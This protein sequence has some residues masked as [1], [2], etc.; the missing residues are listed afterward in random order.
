M[1]SVSVLVLRIV[2]AGVV[3]CG[4]FAVHSTADAPAAG[5]QR[6]GIDPTEASTDGMIAQT[7]GK[8]AGMYLLPATDRCTHGP[9]VVPP[10][11]RTA[12]ADDG[13][14][15]GYP[16]A[17]PAVC[18][19]DGSSG[20]RLE[21]L[22]V[23]ALGAT[24]RYSKVVNQ[25]RSV[26]TDVDR[27]LALSA[28]QTGGSR[29][30]RFAHDLDC[31]VTVTPVMLNASELSTVDSTFDGLYNRG[32]SRPDRKYIAFVDQ[33]TLCGV[34]TYYNDDSKSSANDNNIGPD[35]ARL[36]TSCWTSQITAHETF[37]MMGA[38]QDSA[39]HSSLG[40]HCTDEW[41]AMCYSDAPY[42]PSMNTV[43]TDMASDYILDCNK[44]DYF[45]TNPGPGNYLS[46][47]WNTA[48]N[49]FMITS[50][51][52]GR[53]PNDNFAAATVLPAAAASING[54]TFGSTKEAT[55]FADSVWYSWT[56]S[57]SGTATLLLTDA[58][59][60]IPVNNQ[61][62]VFTGSAFPL[63]SA[64]GPFASGITQTFTVTAGVRYSL[65]VQ[66]VASS[67]EEGPFQLAV[68]VA[69]PPCDTFGASGC[70]IL[71]TGESKMGSVVGAT[72]QAGEPASASGTLFYSWTPTSN[73]LATIHTQ[74]SSFDT[75]LKVFVGTA[76]NA[77]TEVASNDDTES[78]Y[79][80]SLRLMASAGTTY[81][82]RVSGYATAVGQSKLTVDSG[83][84]LFVPIQPVRIF[85]TRTGLGGYTSM[86]GPLESR[87][88]QVVGASPV[89]S[90]ATAV[91]ANVTV[92]QPY[93]AGYASVYPSG[94]AIPNASNLNFAA[95]QTAPNLTTTVLGKS[96]RISIFN[97]SGDG[98]HF[99]VDV[100]GYYTNTSPPGLLTATT[101]TRVHDSRMWGDAGR[102]G[103]NTTRA[104]QVRGGTTPV[105]LTATAV[106]A[107]I[108]AVDPTGDSFIS[109]FPDGTSM[110]VVSNLNVT[111][112]VT[113]A[114]LVT[115]PIGA[116]NNIAIYNNSSTV[117][118]LV[119]IVGYY[120]PS[121]GGKFTALPPTRILESRPSSAWSSGEIR[122]VQVAGSASTPVPAN[123]TAVLMNLTAVTPT[124]GGYLTVAPAGQPLPVVSSLNFRATFNVPNLVLIRVGAGGSINI[125]NPAG[126][127][128]II[129]DVVG[130]VT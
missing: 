59:A 118:M 28:A 27:T 81:W 103:P 40:G 105:P 2:I 65:R 21:I 67:Q 87:E 130:Y 63:T 39:P 51:D 22:Y 37:H 128:H 108:T 8:C 18:D 129:A 123:A 116:T 85:D 120:S 92:T 48:D 89:P 93:A 30:F 73:G 100:A 3:F 41:D 55:E 95:W 43:C 121:G 110:P 68:G 9:D 113:V 114:N 98:A 115:V 32:F 82:I 50:G 84:G 76:V 90:T 71:A 56:P 102:W 26:T 57:A 101:P 34:A 16:T 20:F 47:H 19:G 112:G 74:G 52:N 86:F 111:N 109:V 96:G 44:D 124:S 75:Y 4:P 33:N 70:T 35:W 83:L 77:L 78:D 6:T 106:V 53:P 66:S 119:D 17:P 7:S 107:N 126:Q 69:A 58:M 46:T 62:Q 36:D 127:T 104:I 64:A 61:V 5:A 45:N 72:T 25:I 14:A 11:Q 54:T 10:T 79:T 15:N 94:Q 31:R 117:H 24:N 42:Y 80:S 38:V 97:G 13:T 60:A 122:S 12:A 23:Y 99:F 49:R 91:V 125:Y 29:H 88:V 1:R